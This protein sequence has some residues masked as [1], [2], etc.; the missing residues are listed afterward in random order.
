MRRRSTVLLL[1]ALSIWM[2]LPQ[3]SGAGRR[4]ERGPFLLVSLASLGVVT[5][6]CD[7][8]QHPSL[9]LGFRAF[10]KSADTYVTLRAGGG[11]ILKRHLVP[12]AAVRFPYVKPQRQQLEIVQGTEAGT[13]HAYVSV[14][15][16]SQSGPS[17]CWSYSPPATTVRLTAR[18]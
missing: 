10:T 5:W 3:I 14:D 7:P 1:L 18:R 9:A 8:A 15:F 6:R 11:T 12:G 13:L 16:T 4:S 2:G 17:H